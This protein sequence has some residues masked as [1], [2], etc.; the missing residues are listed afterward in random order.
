MVVVIIRRVTCIG[1]L[2]W[3]YVDCV[4]FIKLRKLI[5]TNLPLK[6]FLICLC[7]VK[8]VY[9]KSIRVLI[10]K[11]R[12]DD[13]TLVIIVIMIHIY[14][15]MFLHSFIHLCLL[16]TY[17]VLLKCMYAHLRIYM[18]VFLSLLLLFWQLWLY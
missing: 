1:C 6:C 7:T 8:C 11:I 16:M 9:P 13:T 4:H 2:G 5:H 14:L 15:F 12:Y 18:N 3:E 17:C 10:A